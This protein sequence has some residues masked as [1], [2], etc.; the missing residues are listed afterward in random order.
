[1]STKIIMIRHGY[2]VANRDKI[3]AGHSN[4]PLDAIGVEQARRVGEFFQGIHGGNCGI[5]KYGIDRVDAVYSSD[6]SRAYDTAKAAADVLGLDVHKCVGLREV[7]GGKYEGL[8]F[9]TIENRYPDE[10]GIWQTDIGRAECVGGEKLTDFACR[11]VNAVT[12]IAEE[13]ESGTVIIGTHATPIRVICTLAEGLPVEDMARVPWVSN[14][15]VSIFEYGDDKRFHCIC[16]S[17]TDHLGNLMTV[18]P[19]GV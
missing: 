4:V 8:P 7:F 5:R 14:A 17:I 1:M 19:A 3:F 15:S 2:S 13:W 10:Y 12:E 18:L 6:L 9:T 11:I 16:K